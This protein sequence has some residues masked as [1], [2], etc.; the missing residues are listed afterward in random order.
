MRI[1]GPS[2]GAHIPQPA[3]QV[4]A[5]KRQHQIRVLQQALQSQKMTADRLVNLLDPKGQNLDLRA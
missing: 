2:A 1:Q 3:G 4:E 5:M